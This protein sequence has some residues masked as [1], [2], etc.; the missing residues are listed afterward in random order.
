MKNKK[1]SIILLCILAALLIVAL[2]LFFYVTARITAD[3]TTEPSDNQHYIISILA[4]FV[5]EFVM[6]CG[7]MLG[8]FIVAATGLTVSIFA[9]K[10]APAGFLKGMSIGF[11][12]FYAVLAFNTTGGAFVALHL[13]MAV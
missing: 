13:L 12:V 1:K 3:E 6:L 2:I 8:E 5:S 11:L 10:N 7:L 9:V 4:E